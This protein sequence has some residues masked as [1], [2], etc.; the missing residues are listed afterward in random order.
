MKDLSICILAGGKSS[1]MGR[2]KGLMEIAGKPMVQYLV[3]TLVEI[4]FPAQIIAHDAAYHQFGLE[5]IE[6]EILEKGPLGG[7]L[8]ALRHASKNAVCLLSCDMPFLKKE[9]LKSLIAQSDDY[10]IT[11]SSFKNRIYP[12]PGIYPLRVTSS[13]EEHVAANKL[14]LQNFILE[15]PHQIFPLDAF[16]EH[17]ALEFLNINTPEDSVKAE[18]WLRNNS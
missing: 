8:T 16:S 15:K 12:F 9:T 6:D 11:I 13:V 17:C 7:L 14:K 3:E 18:T 1:R 4:P 10:S 2:D 5:V